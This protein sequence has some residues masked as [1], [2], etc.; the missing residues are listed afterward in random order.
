MDSDTLNKPNKNA[1]RD[2]WYAYALTQGKTED[3]LED[4]KRDYIAAMF[5]DEADVTPEDAKEAAY[6]A[7]EAMT[8]K[9]APAPVRAGAE[10]LPP[11]LRATAV[12]RPVSS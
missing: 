7:G 3:E 1:S 10:D 12:H 5:D 6:E 4:V 2:D 9:D 8:A 11:Y